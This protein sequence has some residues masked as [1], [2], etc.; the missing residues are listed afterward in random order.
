MRAASSWSRHQ[1]PPASSHRPALGCRCRCCSRGRLGC[2]SAC[3]AAAAKAERTAQPDHDHSACRLQTR[4]PLQCNPTLGARA[5][6]ARSPLACGLPLRPP[7]LLLTPPASSSLWRR[8]WLRRRS[9]A[10][11]LL[12]QSRHDVRLAAGRFAG[13]NEHVHWRRVVPQQQRL[14]GVFMQYGL[15]EGSRT[16]HS[17]GGSM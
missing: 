16:D 2:A 8:L 4:K 12:R 15:F 6:S 3:S 7:T 10:L 5:L 11:Q 9:I 14:M 17:A 13:W 1:Q